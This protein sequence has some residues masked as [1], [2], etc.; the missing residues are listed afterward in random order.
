MPS[1]G[2]RFSTPPPLPPEVPILGLTAAGI[3]L[4]IRLV[5]RPLTIAT[6]DEGFAATLGI[7]TRALSAAL[8]GLTALAA[9]TAFSAVGSILTIAMLICPAAT[10]RLLTDDLGR[11]MR[12]SL[13]AGAS[14]AVIGTWA[15]GYLPLLLGLDFTVSAA[16]SIATVSGLFLALAATYGPRRHA[17]AP[18]A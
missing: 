16:G 12:L 1:V 10:A 6:F 2:P 5:W 17:T 9:V 18:Q 11:Q 7:P 4:A 14:S 13:L 15:A 3:L 8:V